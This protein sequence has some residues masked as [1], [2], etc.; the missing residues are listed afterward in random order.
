MKILLPLSG[1]IQSPV[2]LAV[3]RVPIPLEGFAQ[4]AISGS[5]VVTIGEHEV[6]D[7]TMFVDRPKQIFP[8]PSDLLVGLIHTPRTGSARSE[9]AS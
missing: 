3:T 1:S 8:V 9:D 7:L 6:D 5:G 4:E 2:D